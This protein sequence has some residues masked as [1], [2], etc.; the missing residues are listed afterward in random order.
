MSTGHTDFTIEV[1]NHCGGTCTG[2]QLSVNERRAT[3]PVLQPFQFATALDAISEYDRET[4][5]AFRALLTLGD[6]PWLPLEMQKQFYGMAADRSIPI[7]VTMTMVEAARWENY[8]AGLAAIK[9]ADPTAVFDVT[10]DPIR[11]ER[12][13]DYLDRL[14]YA[15]AEAPELHATVL[16]SEAILTRKD[17]ESLADFLSETLGGTPVLLGFTPSIERLRGMNY[18]YDVHSAAR[19][20]KRF[21]NRT[22]EG[23][24]LLKSDLERFAADGKYSDF[25]K[26]TFHIGPGL[27]VWPTAYTMF[28]DVIIDARNGGEA[29]GSIHDQPLAQILQG[30]VTRRTS[31]IAEAWMMQGPFGCGDCQHLSACT[32]NGIGAARKTYSN[33]EFRS[34]SCYGPKGILA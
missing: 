6:I 18:G 9:A 17:P 16:L 3:G 7:G 14:L 4:G 34:G 11:L 8:R 19:F 28:G 31:V 26:Q 32:F 2:C 24:L 25:I 29:L 21:Y 23:S 1:F 10:I 22:P 33:Y 13:P 15:F 5:L 20:A 27:N 12:Q 30:P